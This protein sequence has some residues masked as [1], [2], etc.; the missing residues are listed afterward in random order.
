MGPLL[1]LHEVSLRYEPSQ[2]VALSD[3]A[4]EV[5]AAEYVVVWGPR[6]S[7]RS[8]V[9]AV[10]AGLVSPTSGR[11]RFD[12]RPPRQSLGREDGIGWAVDGPDAI[13]AAG[14]ATVF[15]QIMWPVS[16]VLSPQQARA[17][18]EAALARCAI[19]ELAGQS[20]WRLSQPERVRLLV[21]RAL[22]RR[23]RLVMLDEPT[24]GVPAPDAR[25]LTEFIRSLVRDG[26]A[27]LVTTDDSAPLAGSRSLSLQRGVLRGRMRAERGGV[28]PLARR[29]GPAA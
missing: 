19:S 27:V 25:E 9:L 21:A 24:V 6:R 1:V 13:L 15:E 16:G 8:S 3:V 26:I 29:S 20:P 11:V 17:R 23:P 2:A 7:G 5:G 10:A 12:G 14:G 18:V 22:I 4:L 28:V